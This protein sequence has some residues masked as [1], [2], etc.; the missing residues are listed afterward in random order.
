MSLLEIH[1][2]SKHFGGLVA[3]QNVELNVE[4]GKIHAVIG[5]NGA[6]K[7]TLLNV[8]AGSVRQTAGKV[9]FN[10]QDISR[11]RADRRVGKGIAKTFQAGVLLSKRTVL[12]NIILGCHLRTAEGY[13]GSI[14]GSTRA[15]S[16]A[17]ATRKRALQIAESMG[18]GGWENKLASDL[19][20]GLQRILGLCIALAS[21]PR[22]LMLDE[23][24]TGMNPTETTETMGLIERLRSQGITIV[25]VEHNMKAVMGL[26]DRITVLSYGEKIAEGLPDEIRNNKCVIEAYLGSST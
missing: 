7:S 6:G 15:R 17:A 23:P 18:L 25:L 2:V 11:L 4:E 13:W 5:P 21:A 16:A 9:V 12:D 8:I 1:K 20:H 19:P 3:L 26:S 22:L 24:V 10:G 14:L